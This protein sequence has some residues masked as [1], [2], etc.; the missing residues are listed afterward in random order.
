MSLMAEFYSSLSKRRFSLLHDTSVV[1]P[2][3]H[4]RSSNTVVVYLAF[5]LEC[6]K[7]TESYLEKSSRNR[8]KIGDCGL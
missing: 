6:Y 5:V 8:Q 1:W 3:G 2:P 7:D 4:H